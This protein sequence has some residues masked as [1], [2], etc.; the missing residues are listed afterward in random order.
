MVRGLTILLV[1]QLI[2]EIASRGLALPVPGPVLGLMLL[3]A[4]LLAWGRGRSDAEV[5]ETAVARAGDGLLANLALLFVPAG[6]GVIQYGGLL[7]AQALPIALALVGSTALTLV[8][9]ALVFVGVSRLVGH[10]AADEEAPAREEA[11]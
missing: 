6:V 10:S 1:C 7:R 3:V 8:V 4:G 9:T 11:R 5:A 2:G